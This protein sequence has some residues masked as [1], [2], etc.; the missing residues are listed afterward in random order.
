[1]DDDDDDDELDEASAAASAASALC[2]VGRARSGVDTVCGG[3]VVRPAKYSSFVALY[4]L[5]DAYAMS[6][7]AAASIPKVFFMN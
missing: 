4:V 1:M 7:V 6:T 2:L 3:V 5:Y